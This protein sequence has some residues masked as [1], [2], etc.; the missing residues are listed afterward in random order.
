M[1]GD[2]MPLCS[3]CSGFYAGFVLGIVSLI[4]T[5]RLGRC[6][7]TPMSS[8]LAPIAL[9]I[10]FGMEAIGERLGLWTTSNEIRLLLGLLAGAAINL[11]LTP[12]AIQLLGCGSNETQ[13][14]VWAYWTASLSL[15]GVFF[16]FSRVD[17]I[18]VFLAVCSIFG[19]ILIYTVLNVAIAS[20]LLKSSGELQNPVSRWAQLSGLSL[21]IFGGEWLA[22]RLIQ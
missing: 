12:L 10:G 3:R 19:L 8:Q 20:A 18:L 22:V 16:F 15:S 21:V 7:P 4:V 13:N 6:S 1:G 14:R 17:E 11:L 2:P 5:R 9:L